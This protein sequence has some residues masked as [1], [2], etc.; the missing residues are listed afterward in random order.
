M[1]FSEVNGELNLGIFSSEFHRVAQLILDDL[2]NPHI[3]PKDTEK[4]RNMMPIK[5]KDLPNPVLMGHVLDGI[6][7]VD[8]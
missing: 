7:G 8:E 6:H 3:I 1:D 2:P 5:S 4:D